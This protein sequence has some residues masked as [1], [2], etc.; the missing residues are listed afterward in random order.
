MTSQYRVAIVKVRLIMMLPYA[1]KNEV[2][3]SFK[4]DD[5]KLFK[6]VMEI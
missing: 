5:F 2:T 3:V 6:S 4:W 1:D